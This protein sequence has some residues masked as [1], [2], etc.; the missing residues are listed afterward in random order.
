[1][2]AR[3]HAVVE[4]LAKDPRLEGA[5]R[6]SGAVA[7]RISGPPA[8]RRA[9]LGGWLGHPAHPAFTDYPL[10]FWASAIVLDRLSGGERAADALLGLGVLAALPTTATGMAEL[11]TTAGESRTI[12]AVHGIGNQIA[13]GLF[14]MSWFSRRRGDRGRGELLALAGGAVVSATAYLGGH[15][16]YRHHAGMVGSRMQPQDRPI[17]DADTA[18][19][20]KAA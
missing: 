7:E 6:W 19:Q 11:T 5:T 14:T 15:L 18:Q 3:L 20:A 9:L 10:G 2:S 13:L 4:S 16:V 17:I 12:A 1:V 8:L